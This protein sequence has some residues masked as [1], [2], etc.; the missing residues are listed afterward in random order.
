MTQFQRQYGIAGDG[1]RLLVEALLR[2][3]P[4]AKHV[5]AVEL[6]EAI[7]VLQDS[8]DPNGARW[9]RQQELNA[10]QARAARGAA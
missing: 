1:L 9:R 6:S 3:C 2:E 4:P 7:E 5:L 10:R 8:L